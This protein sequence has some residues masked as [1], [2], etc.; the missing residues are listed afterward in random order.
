MGSVLS[1]VAAPVTSLIGGLVGANNAPK[2]TYQGTIPEIQKQDLISQLNSLTPQQQ[3]LTKMLMSQ[4]QGQGP[5]PAQIMLNQATNKNNQQGAGMIASQKGIS[6][7]LAA[8]LI[9]QNTAGANQQ[10]AG[11][12]ALMG[13]QQ[14]L[15]AENLLSGN[16]LGQQ[17]TLE[18]AQ[19]AQNNAINQGSLGAQGI[20][21]SAAAQNNANANSAYGGALNGFGGGLGSAFGKMK[22]WEGGQVPHYDEGGQVQHIDPD[23]AKQVSDSFKKALGFRE[24]G[25]VPAMVSPGE[26]YIPPHKVEKARKGNPM[27][28]GEKIPGKP[29][30]PGNRPEND[31]KKKTLKAGGVVLPNSVTQSDNPEEKAKMFMEELKKHK[32][33]EGGSEGFNKVLEAKRHLQDMHDSMMKFNKAMKSAK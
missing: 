1:A 23:K 17:G 15:S 31:T 6:P 18:Q 14:Q 20:S 19:A 21:A 32:E 5:N 26:V 24:G 30:F 25:E 12:G 4:S 13:A 11:Q 3:E 7:S 33:S 22:G 28:E 29:K 8:R 2:N 10:A 27:K 9:A 16:L